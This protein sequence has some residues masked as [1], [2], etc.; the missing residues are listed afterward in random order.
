MTPS[1]GTYYFVQGKIWLADVDLRSRIPESG[2]E[3]ISNWYAGCIGHPHDLAL[4][5]SANDCSQNLHSHTW[6]GNGNNE[7]MYGAES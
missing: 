1:S 7:G 5:S 3:I 4:D 2:V 6:M